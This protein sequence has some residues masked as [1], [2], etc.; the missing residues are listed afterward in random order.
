MKLHGLIL[1][2]FLLPVQ[3]FPQTIE[4]PSVNN[5]F[6]KVTSYDELS[7]YIN[8]LDEKSDL[9]TVEICGQSEQL[10]NIYA[11]K[12]SAGEFGADPEKI[13]VLIFAQQHGNEQSGK[14]GALLLARDLL[15]EENR[16][17]FEKIDL[18]LIPQV[19]PDGSEVNQRLNANG[20][21]LNRNH[22]ILTESETQAIHRIFVQYLFEVTMDV[23]EYSPYNEEWKNYGYRKNSEV[24][25]GTTTNPNVSE[26][27]RRL[28][29]EKVLPFIL[30]YLNDRGFSSF[31]YCPGGP[32]GVNYIRNSTFDINDG[33]Q[34]L[35]IQ[36][37][38]SFIQE[39]MNGTDSYIENLARR[40]EGQLAGMRGLLEYVYQNGGNIRKLV[41]K[42][43]EKLISGIPGRTVSIQSEHTATGEKLELPLLSYFTGADTIVTVND[44][45]SVVKSIYDVSAPVGYLLP[46]ELSS[47]VTRHSFVHS[48]FPGT[49]DLLIEQYF[50]ESIDSIDF[51]GDMTVDP[52]FTVKEFNE[53]I[54]LEN[55]IYLPVAQL[56]G[57]MIILGL[58]PK[59]ELGLAT[60]K[61]YAELLKPGEAYPVLRVVKKHK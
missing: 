35:G 3:L 4:A 52:T 15:K 40:A 5:N 12:F 42:E 19:N 45:R 37:T 20:F 24:T 32:P 23:H 25:L 22:L 26:R 48:G 39:G 13:R 54:T 56:K 28:S 7:A 61:S 10:R 43:R 16:Y 33:R 51:E 6:S 47:W 46:G 57:N 34:S 8:K 38:L 55:Y 41:A 59:S 27:I 11:M 17:L 1:I 50:I 44:Y 31:E 49:D 30:G 29:R 58:E 14:E 21:D 36:N 2:S 60:Y 53:N 18:A 9:L